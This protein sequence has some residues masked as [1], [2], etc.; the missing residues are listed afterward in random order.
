MA[1]WLEV[2]ASGAPILYGEGAVAHAGQLFARGDDAYAPPQP[3]SF[4]A[5]NYPPLAFAIVALGIRAGVE[6][7]F[8]TLRAA[9]IVATLGVA[10][11]VAWRARREPLVG[12]ALA[13]AFLSLFPVQSWG[14]AHKPDPLAVALTAAAVVVAGSGWRRAMLGGVLGALAIYAKPT[15]ALP[16]GAVLTYLLWREPLTGRRMGLSLAVALGLATVRFLVFSDRDGLFTHLVAWNALGYSVGSA[17][18]LAVAGVTMLGVFAIVG[19]LRADGRFGAYLAGAFAIVVLG[20][21]EGATINYLLD[22]AAAATLAMAPRLTPAHGLTGALLGGQLLATLALSSFGAF[23]P[24]GGW[25]RPERVA[26]ASD[27]ARTDLHL[28]EDSGV[29]VA[30]GIEPV[31]DDLFLWSRLVAQGALKDEITPRVRASEFATVI[32]ELPLE[33]LESAP[34]FERQRWSG[35]LV[36]AVLS[37]YRLERAVPG[38]YRYVRRVGVARAE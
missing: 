23:G 31:V 7:P 34:A 5:A 28:A 25:A 20:G 17:L 8:T 11:L 12:A 27:L 14:P 16:L 10:A 6:G 29:L 2:L 13:F 4:V 15:A 1:G 3:G 35:E 37:S 38:H 19:A 24:T 21:R 32:A 33:T 22:L 36:R 9:S 18:L 26:L 30:N